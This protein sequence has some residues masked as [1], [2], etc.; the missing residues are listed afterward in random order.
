MIKDN[1]IIW[2]IGN[3]G[4]SWVLVDMLENRYNVVAY[5][6]NN[7]DGKTKVNGRAVIPVKDIKT[8]VCENNVAAIL[9]A[10]SNRGAEMSIRNQIQKEISCVWGGV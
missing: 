5:C 9:I 4:S 6:D 3:L 7:S 1:C 2:G 10:V 8:Y